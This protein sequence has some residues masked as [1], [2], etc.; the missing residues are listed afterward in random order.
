MTDISNFELISKIGE[1]SFSTVFKARHIQS[2]KFY[3]L[4]VMEKKLIN[5]VTNNLD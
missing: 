5:K 4:K 3:A 1:G 2:G